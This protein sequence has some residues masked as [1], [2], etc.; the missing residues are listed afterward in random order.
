MALKKTKKTAKKAVK[1]TAKKT[2]TKGTTK[3]K[4]VKSATKTVKKSAAKTTTKSAKKPS[5]AKKTKTTKTPAARKTT[6]K[7][8]KGLSLRERKILEIRK[9]LV[10]QRENLLSG[11]EN[12]MNSLPDQTIF[13]DLGDQATAETDRNFM[14]RLRG[15]EQRL[16]KKIDDAL[17]RIDSGV[18]GICEVC[19]EEIHIKRL[20]ARP[21][22]TM[23]IDC[24]TAQEEEEKLMGL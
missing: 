15:R 10:K 2:G 7:A 14:L 21:V 3:K 24:K 18:F 16:L 5:S 22:T 13:P 6:A 9:K 1:K 4:V 19:G 8:K 17:E 11:A 23:C 20:E 12:T